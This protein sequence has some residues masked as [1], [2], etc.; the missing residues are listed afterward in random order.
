MKATIFRYYSDTRYFCKN[1]ISANPQPQ[2][3]SSHNER[4][5]DSG[6]LHFEGKIKFQLSKIININRSLR[7][8]S[9]LPSSLSFP[10]S[11]FRLTDKW[12]VSFF[13]SYYFDTMPKKYFS[14]LT[15]GAIEEQAKRRASQKSQN[16]NRQLMLVIVLGKIEKDYFSDRQT[17]FTIFC[18][19]TSLRSY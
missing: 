2:H 6:H 7:C 10:S 1:L 19:W 8:T 14:G 16:A 5:L 18:V 12:R 13:L 17:R 3:V 4:A 9:S 11:S 15:K